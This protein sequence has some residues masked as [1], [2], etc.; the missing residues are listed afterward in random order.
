M[1]N[2]KSTISGNSAFNKSSRAV[3]SVRFKPK[4]GCES[5]PR[6]SSVLSSNV[7]EVL[8]LETTLS[9][10]YLYQQTVESGGYFSVLSRMIILY[11]LIN[12]ATLDTG[13]ISVGDYSSAAHITLSSNTA[14]WRT[15]RW[16]VGRRIVH[17]KI[18]SHL[19][20]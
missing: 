15:R 10:T 8:L 20:A 5:E 1:C 16:Q 7:N 14:S 19:C 18:Q 2:E 11:D 9:V 17:T 3:G 12:A 4:D 6:A 13:I